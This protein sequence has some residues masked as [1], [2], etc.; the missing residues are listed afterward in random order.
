MVY[1]HRTRRGTGGA[2]PP[3]QPPS[4][5]KYLTFEP[6][7]GGWNNVR[8]AFETVVV[9]ARLTGRTLVLPPAQ[10]IYLLKQAALGFEVSND[11]SR[12]SAKRLS[13]AQR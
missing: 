13:I 4:P 9:I 12:A 3:R 11:V 5:R 10:R 2:P 7:Q 1:W 6:D 8:M